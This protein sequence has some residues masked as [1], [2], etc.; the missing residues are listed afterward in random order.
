M[1]IKNVP[2]LILGSVVVTVLASFTL[3]QLL[4][5]ADPVPLEIEAEFLRERNIVDGE[6][7]APEGYTYLWAT[8]RIDN[9]SE[10]TLSFAASDVVLLVHGVS[11]TMVEAFVAPGTLPSSGLTLRPGA[12]ARATLGWEAPEEWRRNA[13]LVHFAEDSEVAIPLPEKIHIYE[14]DAGRA[15]P[16]RLGERR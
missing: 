11:A 1:K 4:R 9:V 7:K 2:Y 12:T 13:E 3:S 8:L 16:L 10:E 14:G 6:S 5:E 15:V